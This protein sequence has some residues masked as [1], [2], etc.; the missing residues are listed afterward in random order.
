M[1]KLFLLTLASLSL[2]FSSVGW[3][4]INANPLEYKEGKTI[5]AGVFTED[6]SI[7][8]KRPG[9]VIVHQWMGITDH[10]LNK[11]KELAEKGYAVLVADIYGKGTK[12]A[13]AEEAGRVSKF[14]KDDLKK[15]RD[16]V[17]A[18]VEALKK[19]KNVDGAKVVV[20]GYCFGGTAALEALRAQ[21]PI[22]G[23]V[24]FHG[25]L[26][27]TKPLVMDK[28]KIKTL[29][30]HGAI[31]PMVPPQDTVSL[32]RELDAAKV[33]YQFIAY[34][35]AVHAFTQKSAGQD[36][37]KGVAY[38]ESADRRSWGALMSFLEEVAPIPSATFG[39]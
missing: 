21:L 26:T 38:N 18:A 6:N 11:A 37:S 32:M 30:L 29:V 39:P 12:V 13:T 23:A 31:D 22:V 1:K 2:L 28:K 19:Q 16:R 36:I 8:V 34:S 27:T 33:D 9:I 35:G 20:L 4:S 24:S 25:A 5:L 15:L 3:A 7:K 10:E 17:A 14:Y